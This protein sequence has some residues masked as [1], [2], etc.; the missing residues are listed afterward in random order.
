MSKKNH[1]NK[2]PSA[3]SS[4]STVSSELYPGFKLQ[5]EINSLVSLHSFKA[6]VRLGKS[7]SFNIVIM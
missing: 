2:I 1:K 3:S 6:I 4:P 5:I 7:K